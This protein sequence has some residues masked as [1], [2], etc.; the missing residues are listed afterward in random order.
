MDKKGEDLIGIIPSGGLGKRM[1]PY[2][3]LKEL[4]TVGYKTYVI[5]GVEKKIPKVLSEYTIDNMLNSSINNLIVIINENK[6]ELIKFYGD[7]SQ[8]NTY[9]AYLC[10][11]ID[12]RHYGMPVALEQAYP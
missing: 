1:K 5:N 2:R 4:T 6:S 9:I 12:G 8:Y 11:V 10:Q 7:G 3:A